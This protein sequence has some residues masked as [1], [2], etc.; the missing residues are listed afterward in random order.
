MKHILVP[1]LIGFLLLFGPAAAKA[2]P[3]SGE[4]DRV[5]AATHVFDDFVGS[6][7]APVLTNAKGIAIIPG[8]VKAG[9]IFG[10]ELG[11]GVLLTRAPDGSWSPPAFISVAGGT[12][13]LQ[14]GGEARDIV[15][16][17]NTPGSVNFIENGHLKL[18]GD[19]S[20]TAGPVGGD[21]AVTSDM[22][23]VYSYVR[24]LGAFIGAT[25]NGSVLSF[26]SG[27]NSNFYG[28]SDPLRMQAREIPE[29]ARRLDCTVARA[30]NAPSEYCS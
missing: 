16:V 5:E 1:A 3:G 25:I 11:Q 27:A 6:I 2:M 20:V 10:G 14:I 4:M 8:E 19:A 12:F 21:F 23:E 24:N 15:L 7:P 9:F 22:P 30:T 28:V 29:P 13:G 17:F 26:D 18:G